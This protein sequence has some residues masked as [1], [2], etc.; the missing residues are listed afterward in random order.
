MQRASTM[1]SKFPRAL[2]T[3]SFAGGLAMA[4]THLVL[5]LNPFSWGETAFGVHLARELNAAGQK[6]VLLGNRLAAPLFRS[7]PFPC[8]LVPILPWALLLDGLR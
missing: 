7:L 2:P 5:C 8:E 6:V 4:G 3:S 1:T